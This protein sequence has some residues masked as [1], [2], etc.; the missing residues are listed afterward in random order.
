MFIPEVGACKRTLLGEVRTREDLE[1]YWKTSGF[2]SLD[3]W[4][5]KIKEFNPSPSSRL[6]LYKVELTRRLK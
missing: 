3:D 5:A 4:W 6:Y 2:E 1:E